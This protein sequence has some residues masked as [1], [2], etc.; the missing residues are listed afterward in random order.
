MDY[1][2]GNLFDYFKDRRLAG[3]FFSSLFIV[4]AGLLNGVAVG[5]ATD[6]C[7]WQV[8]WSVARP[9]LAIFALACLWVWVRWRRRRRRFNHQDNHHKSFPLSRD[10]WVKARSK[11]AKQPTNHNKRS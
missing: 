4:I 8:D 5:Q 6:G 2:W 1:F 3:V 7:R 10:E 11:L 9:S